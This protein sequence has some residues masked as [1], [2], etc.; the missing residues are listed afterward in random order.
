MG[1]PKTEV[2]ITRA[3]RKRVEAEEII[4]EQTVI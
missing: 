1:A 3:A 4:V 2:L